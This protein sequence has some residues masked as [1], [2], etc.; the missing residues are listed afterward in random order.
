MILLYRITDA[1][2]K[3]DF[4]SRDTVT[5]GRYTC[6]PCGE[7]SES[8]FEYMCLD[9][10]KLGRVPEGDSGM[11]RF[12]WDDRTFKYYFERLHSEI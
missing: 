5:K 6:L 1:Q 10:M 8:D 9:V 4:L 12:R 2:R 3:A 7:L 11:I